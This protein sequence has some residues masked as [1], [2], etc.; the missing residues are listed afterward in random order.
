MCSASEGSPAAL[1]KASSTSGRSGPR[2]HC[3]A[4]IEKPRLGK[5]R[6]SAGSRSAA[7]RRSGSLPS[8]LFILRP[9]GSRAAN[10]RTR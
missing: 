3:A 1:P 6:I 8:R 5:V 9:L 2:S 10:S 7:R 4:G